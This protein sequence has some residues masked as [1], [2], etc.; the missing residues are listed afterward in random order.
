MAMDENGGMNSPLLGDI[1]YEPPKPRATLPDGTDP[2]LANAEKPILDDVG[3]AESFLRTAP[4]PGGVDPR[5][6]GAV[7]P[8]LDDMGGNTPPP[9]AAS[10]PRYQEL[11]AEQI[12]VLQQQRAAQGQPPYTEDEIAEL[13]ADFIERQRLQAQE[14]ALA[15]QAAAAAQASIQLEETTYEAPEKKTPVEERLPQVN[16][17]DLL[18]EAAPEPERRSSF[19]QADLEE[20]R[21]NAAKR[22]AES[23]SETPKSNPE[24]SRKM[25][26]ELRRQQQADLAAA[27]FPVAVVLTILGAIGG[28]CMVIS[29][30]GGYP[31][32][33]ESNGFFDFAG[34]LY[35]L[36][37]A[38]L[39]ILSATIVLRVKAVKGFTSFMFGLSCVLQ[40]VPGL[41]VMLPKRGADSFAVTAITFAISLICCIAVTFVMA[42]SEKVTAYYGVNDRFYD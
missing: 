16:A 12:A 6:A 1:T 21:R 33:F 19:Q 36:L 24:D 20:A 30:F 27:G 42:S 37:G 26:R 14:Q 15:Q 41:V 28:L 5:L 23:L 22:A 8:I 3:A 2:R 9:P 13:K 18:E 38:L 40:L 25:L 11:S 7:A 29:A 35:K 32:G 39:V 4:Q 10:A 17:A 31:D 34:L